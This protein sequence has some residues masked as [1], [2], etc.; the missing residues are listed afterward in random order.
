MYKQTFRFV[1][2]SITIFIALMVLFSIFYTKPV[3]AQGD[4]HTWQVGQRVGLKSG[5]EI[6]DGSGFGY[7]VHTIVPEDDWLVDIID[8]PRYIDGEEWWDISRENL[9]G[10]GTGWVYISQA[11]FN[12]CS[13]SSCSDV[14]QIPQAECEVLVALYNDTDGANWSNNAGWLTTNT[15]FSWYG[16]WGESGHVTDIGLQE[17]NLSGNIPPQISSLTN[18]QNLS[19]SDNQLNGSIPPELGNL[20]NLQ[21]LS[22][23]S[24]QLSGNIPP[25]LGNLTNLL[26]LE[27]GFDIFDGAMGGNQL[28]GNIPRELGGL[29]NLLNL[30][31]NNNQLSGTIPPE[32][33]NL[34]NLQGL[35][36]SWNQ[37]TGSIPSELG[38]LIN[39]YSLHLHNNQLSGSIPLSLSNLINLYSLTLDQNQLSGNIPPGLG[40]LSNLDYINL[41]GNELNGNIP[42]S[43]GNLTNLL[44][45]RLQY[46]QLS[47]NV[48]P[49]LGNLV[50]L[51]NL[52][53]DH[54]QLSGA[55]P[56]S[57]TNLTNLARFRFQDTSLCQPTDAAFQTW[58][59][60]I[61]DVQGTGV[62]CAA[63]PSKPPLVLVH[64]IQLLGD[65]Y[66]CSDGIGRYGSTVNTLDNLPVWL[67]ENYDVWIAHL[68]T[69]PRHTPSLKQNAECLKNQ[70]NE[71]HSTTQQKVIVVA[72]S[73]GGLVSRAC[74]SRSDCR[75]NVKALYTMGSP[76]AGLNVQLVAKILLKQAENYLTAHGLPIPVTEGICLWQKAVCEMG[77][78]E[79]LWFNTENPNKRGIDYTFIGGGTTPLNP[80]WL[81]WP[82]EGYNDG[83]VGRHSAVGWAYPGKWF[84]PPWWDNPAPPRQYWTDEVHVREWG[85]A[86]YE[87]RPEDDGGSSGHRSQAFGCIAYHE[88]LS[89]YTSKPS[90]C[91]EAA[92][93]G[94]ITTADA[95]PALSET[96]I[97]LEGHLANSETVT[98][99]V[100][101][102]TANHSIFYLSWITG[103]VSFSLTQPDGQIIDHVYADNNPDIVSYL[104]S[105]GSS[106]FPPIAT[107]AFT[108]TQ[109]G[110]W[111]LNMSSGDVGANGTN[112]LAFVAMETN[113]NLSFTTNTDF[114][115]V[116]D[117]AALTA[118]LQ[119]S[120]GGIGGATVTVTLNRPDRVTDTLTLTDQGSGVYTENYTIPNTPGYIVTSITAQGNDGGVQFTRQNDTLIQVFSPMAQLN[121]GYADYPE[122]PNEDNLYERLVFEV[123][124]T[125]SQVG[126]YTVS[127]NL[128]KADELIA[129][130]TIYK[131][132]ATGSQTVTLHFNG[133]DIRDSG[134]DGP[135]T[136]SNVIVTDLQSAVPSAL[137][138]DVWTTVVYDH[139]KFGSG[140]SGNVY[141]PIILK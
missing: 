117:T 138:T 106:E 105:P 50:N 87:T 18:L 29:T 15:P 110:T 120:S 86:Y 4:C 85:H 7:V 132:L 43:F 125:A 76:H 34:T 74:L 98:R 94:N 19:L 24:N 69:S 121:G 65:G 49:E 137:A 70:I 93:S 47:G 8:G 27:L 73:M 41:A 67:I 3:S 103:T 40:N 26:Y 100:Q 9:D 124:L 39:T 96:T 55:L 42:S 53:L 38:N 30:Q 79:M 97:T 64:G 119:G 109:S 134:V 111:T 28:S 84:V 71:V 107:Y 33:G 35:G 54:N 52:V 20:A 116:G 31:L 23:Y 136:V 123:D 95:P 104:F 46:N 22:L 88:N 140:S 59:A 48:P 99:S 57:L 130:T 32:L 6:R 68:T 10:G 122:D 75:D 77:S 17:N 21:F 115:N 58:L 11:G 60:G 118:T 91:E 66:D 14:I 78:D 12:L 131:I 51:Q 135:Y 16:I 61:S 13:F 141:L 81:L 63:P 45:L 36:L 114:Y 62:N 92:S 126:T 139:T 37:L 113:R 25:Q 5:A 56:T 44:Q 102:D 127:A 128:T 1:G 133:D 112:Y 101:V 72:H 129:N 108:N 89:G 82:T 90:F 2:V 80:G 83:L